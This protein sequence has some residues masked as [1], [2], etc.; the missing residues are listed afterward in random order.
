VY[1]PPKPII[2]ATASA[3]DEAANAAA[4]GEAC[5]ERD[6]RDELEAEE[7]GPRD[8]GGVSED[9]RE[10]EHRRYGRRRESAAASVPDVPVHPLE[11]DERHDEGRQRRPAERAE[12]ESE[13][14]R[15]GGEPGR[16]C[17]EARDAAA[18]VG[19]PEREL[20]E[21]SDGDARGLLEQAEVLGIL[22]RV[23]L[24]GGAE[25]W[26]HRRERH[27]GEVREA[28]KGVRSSALESG[29]HPAGAR[30]Q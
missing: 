9:A 23:Q 24:R 3:E 1:V 10:R 8:E 16:R 4:R 17:P 18:V 30:H 26:P 2:H 5:A 7:V 14:E 25:R 15:G 22:V 27:D 11:P 13:Q 6:P 28:Q 12:D 21:P 20:V 29:V 19:V